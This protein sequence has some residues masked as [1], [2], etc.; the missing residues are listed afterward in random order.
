MYKHSYE[1]KSQQK[2]RKKTHTHMPPLSTCR[3]IGRRCG[4]L[5]RK[6]CSVSCRS[7]SLCSSFHGSSG[8]SSRCDVDGRRSILSGRRCGLGSGRCCLFGLGL[9]NSCCF[10]RCVCYGVAT[11][12]RLLKSIGRFYRK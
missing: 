1:E 7:G 5:G 9:L 12:S 11:I 2:R 6:S 3:S 10:G 8:D 4:I